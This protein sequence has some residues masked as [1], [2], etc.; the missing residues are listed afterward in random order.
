MLTYVP[1]SAWS[2]IRG[3]GRFNFCHD[4]THR[5]PNAASGRA[6][7]AASGHDISMGPAL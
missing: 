3:V 1:G 5:E 7:P 6:E 2:T 4:D